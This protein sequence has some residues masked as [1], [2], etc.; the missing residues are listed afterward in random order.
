MPTEWRDCGQ[1]ATY[2]RQKRR[3]ANAQRKLSRRIVRAKERASPALR[4][5]KNVE[6]N[7]S[8]YSSPGSRHKSCSAAKISAPHSD[9][10]QEP[11]SGRSRRTAEP[12]LLKNHALAMSIQDNGWRMFLSMLDL[13]GSTVRQE[14]RH[15]R[16]AEYDAN[17]PRLWPHQRAVKRTDA[18]GPRGSARKWAAPPSRRECGRKKFIL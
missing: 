8:A 1:L 2:R 11:R 18:Q 4:E 3:L 9:T 12:N 7:F 6:K 16:P 14:L 17:P 5:A 10:D 15:R 13:Q